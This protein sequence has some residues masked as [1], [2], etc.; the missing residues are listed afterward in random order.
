M[1]DTRAY[2][3]RVYRRRGVDGVSWFQRAPT[4]SLA[5]FEAL[6]IGGE[7]SLVDIGGGASSLVDVLLDAGWRDVSVVDVSP[8]AVTAA[9]DRLGDSPVSWIVADVLRW[10][11]VRHYQVWHDRALFHF[12]TEEEDRAAYRERLRSAVRP[13]S[14]VVIGTFAADGPEMCSG[15][16]VARYDAEDLATALGPDL[17]LVCTHREEHVTPAGIVQPFT[18]VG[19]RVRGSAEDLEE[20]VERARNDLDRVAPESL[21]REMSDGAVV[22]DIRPHEQRVRDGDLV[23]AVV[24]DRNVLEWRAVSTSAYHLAQVDSPDRRI[25][26]VCNQGYASS[27]AAAALRRLGMT[28]ATDLAG[29][30]QAWLTHQRNRLTPTAE[31]PS[32]R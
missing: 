28:R 14:W 12:L 7:A 17:E 5:V 21:E 26:V 18:W 3:D 20:Y 6:G 10:R 24:V 23:G 16:P 27:L 31:P 11:P 29:G 32:P 13:G 15:L 9:E 1:G 2:W 22:V 30:M 25:V 4:G 19:L 8:V